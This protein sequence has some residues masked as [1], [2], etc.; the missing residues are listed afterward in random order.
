MNINYQITDTIIPNTTTEK[1]F[2]D[3]VHKI[4]RITPNKGYLLHIKGR[5]YTDID[6]ATGAEIYRLGYT[7]TATIIGANYAFTSETVKDEKGVYFTAYG[8]QQLAARLEAEA[9]TL[10][11]L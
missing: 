8:T 3:G 2:I 10:K 11:E 6:T 5:D 9:V 1:G 4:Y 7:R